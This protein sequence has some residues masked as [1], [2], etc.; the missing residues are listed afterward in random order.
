[1]SE[2]RRS[3][4]KLFILFATD[5]HRNTRTRALYIFIMKLDC[6]GDFQ[7]VNRECGNEDPRVMDKDGKAFFAS[8]NHPK[9]M[10]K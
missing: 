10:R 3:P 6:A 8:E 7:H 9:L 2:I 4:R 5:P 1:M